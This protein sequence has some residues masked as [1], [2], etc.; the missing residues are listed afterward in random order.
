MLSFKGNYILYVNYYTCIINIIHER[1]KNVFSI[2]CVLFHSSV[3]DSNKVI[4]R[5]KDYVITPSL[6]SSANRSV[7][8]TE[9]TFRIAQVTDKLTMDSSTTVNHDHL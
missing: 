5:V 7:T 3:V 6:E 4:S 1:G 8:C 2:M 9:N